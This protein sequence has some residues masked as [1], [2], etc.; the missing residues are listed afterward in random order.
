MRRQPF[1]GRPLRACGTGRWLPFRPG[2]AH[3][4]SRN[5]VRPLLLAR[6]CPDDHVGIA[7]A[8]HIPRRR[9][10]MAATV[11]L[12]RA[13]DTV[14]VG[15]AQRRQVDVGKPR[16]LAEKHIGRAGIR[17]PVVVGVVCPDDQVGIAVAVHIPRRRHAISRTSH[18]PPR[19]RY[20]SR[21]RRPA[22]QG[23]CSQTP[24]PCRKAHRQSRTPIARC[25]RRASAPTIRS[26]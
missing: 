8:V 12:R 22:K 2:T 20:G 24:T 14:A 7:V 16:R 17:S 1:A 4:R 5:H 15:G 3:R 6:R 10:A 25:C 11:I 21:R 9:H 19:R 18:P 13:V 26:A 23:R